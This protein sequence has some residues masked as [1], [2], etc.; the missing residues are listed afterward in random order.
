MRYNLYL[1]LP[2]GEAVLL[3]FRRRYWSIPV[4]SVLLGRMPAEV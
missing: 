1:T 2:C 4:T 3:V